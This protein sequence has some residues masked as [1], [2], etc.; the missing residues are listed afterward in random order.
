MKSIW[1]WL[2][3]LVAV[4]ACGSD[5]NEP[6]SASDEYQEMQTADGYETDTHQSGQT[7]TQDPAAQ[8]PSQQPMA[9]QQGQTYNQ[10][11]QGG[12]WQTQ[13]P[14]GGQPGMGTQPGMGQS[15][16]D[17]S[18][19]TSPSADAQL[20]EGIVQPEACPLTPGT[21]RRAENIDEGVLLMLREDQLVSQEE[22][23]KRIRCY[24]ARAQTRVQDTQV[25]A[26]DCAFAI[27]GVNA[28]VASD[29]GSVTVRLT[30]SSPD[31]VSTLRQQ[32]RQLARR[33]NQSPQR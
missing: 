21:V 12:T 30:T 26:A 27:P 15:G 29:A 18:Q 5:S 25:A 22:L 17:T 28:I 10:G 1:M 23:E 33:Q 14:S 11:T 3:M 6:Q 13:N 19:T 20:C 32:G 9:G 4:G 7:D 24:E 16:L 31:Q 8:T 2:G